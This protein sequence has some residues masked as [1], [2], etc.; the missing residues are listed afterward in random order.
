MGTVNLNVGLIIASKYP[1]AL[2]KVARKAGNQPYT[3]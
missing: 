2:Q 3:I 1:S